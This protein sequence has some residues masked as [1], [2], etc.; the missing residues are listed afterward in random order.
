MTGSVS[1]W[2]DEA[3]V[4]LQVQKC[5]SHFDLRESPGTRIAEEGDC[6]EKETEVVSVLNASVAAAAVYDLGERESGRGHGHGRG[7]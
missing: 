7:E 3:A 6:E 4:L 1:G 5:L 2:A